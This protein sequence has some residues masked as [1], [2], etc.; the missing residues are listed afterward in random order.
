[1]KSFF[2]WFTNKAKLK[3][4]YLLLLIGIA[5][6]CY[7]VAKLINSDTLDQYR[8]VKIVCAFASGVLFIITSMVFIQKRL[9][10]LLVEKSDTRQNR[11]KADVSK[12]IFNKRVYN[13]G[14]K[15][16]VF[17]GGHGLNTVLRGLKHYTDNITAIVT[18][19]DY[20]ETPTDSKKQLKV[21]PIDDIKESLIALSYNE[22][23]M[24]DLLN[25]TFTEGKLSNLDFADI[26]F[27]A[28][29]KLHGNFAESIE[30]S[31][32]IF[33]I[34]GR[35]LPV[36]LD[37]IKICAELSDGTTIEN[38]NKIPEL[39][40]ESSSKISRVFISPSNAKP[41]TGVL[42]AIR[43]ADAIVI[44]PGSLYT[45]VIPNLLV[46]GIAHEVRESKALKIYVSN[47][48]TEI[49]ET[50]EY[51]L[52]DHLKAIIDYVGEKI[53]DYCIYD[54]GEIIPEFIQKYNEEGRDIVLADTTICKEMGIK[55]VQRNL[56]KIEGDK[57]RH[58]SDIIALTI[59]QLICDELK[60]NDMQNDAQYLMLNN[61]MKES[62]RAIR[63]RLKKEKKFQESGK[64]KYERSNTRS[65]F[66]EKYDN[67][68]NS[69]KNSDETRINNIKNE[70]LKE[71]T[72]IA[73]EQYKSQNKDELINDNDSINIDNIDHAYSN[74]IRDDSD[75][76]N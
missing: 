36:T 45:N 30:N 64:S 3:R 60:F 40:N 27:L 24:E 69:I 18:L 72:K 28:M 5:L 46:K 52:S 39:V 42:E 47:I 12:L 31:K 32:N 53:I 4:W 49:G 38:R 15:V 22:N 61:K 9:L 26:Y 6:V 41:A 14:P 19:S 75:D 68:I 29:N 2:S 50:D 34:T 66:N 16:V 54:T 63:K 55:L 11:N 21:L 58:D 33:N 25:T 37:P 10:E 43:E 59:I 1:M 48:M 23:E 71:S 8:I 74:F 67:R 7:G 17:G 65:K 51:T 70:E 57:I 35:V 73:D 20:G 13:Q 44:G 62:K 76:N 56:S